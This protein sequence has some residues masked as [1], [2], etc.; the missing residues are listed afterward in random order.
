MLKQAADQMSCCDLYS[1]GVKQGLCKVKLKHSS[2]IRVDTALLELVRG[3]PSAELGGVD[4]HLHQLCKVE[5]DIQLVAGQASRDENSSGS[6]A[7]F[8]REE[9]A[10][11]HLAG[12]NELRKL[13]PCASGILVDRLHY[14]VAVAF[15]VTVR[16]LLQEAKP[17]VI[18]GLVVD[19]HERKACADVKHIDCCVN[20]LHVRILVSN[21]CCIIQ[22]VAEERQ[23]HKCVTR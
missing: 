13:L 17:D 23:V 5:A 1:L 6:E 2:H 4:V 11:D 18:T 8:D 22:R 9:R 10:N 14:N 3:P 20:H 16:D 7:L 12:T 19:D 15:S 21:R